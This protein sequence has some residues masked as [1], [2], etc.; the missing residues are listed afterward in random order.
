M[1]LTPVDAIAAAAAA[2]EMGRESELG[3][4]RSSC[5]GLQG[6]N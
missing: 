3:R 2:V 6:S 5:L 4:G 1:S